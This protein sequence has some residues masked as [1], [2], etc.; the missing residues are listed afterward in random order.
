[1][2]IVSPPP[3]WQFPP[4]FSTETTAPDHVC[5]H[6][7]FSVQQIPTFWWGDLINFKEIKI[8]G[9]RR[10]R[11]GSSTIWFVTGEGRKGGG[12]GWGKE[13]QV[14]PDH[15]QSRL[16]TPTTV[17]LIFHH[18]C[19]LKLRLHITCHQ[20]LANRLSIQLPF[21]CFGLGNQG[22]WKPSNPTPLLKKQVAPKAPY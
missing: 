17:L 19:F 14:N 4:N 13:T 3:Y 2:V 11:V 21:P 12:G 1:M 7:S 22:I 20:F 10:E 9:K 15:L 6:F 8:L 16:P 5:V 18:S